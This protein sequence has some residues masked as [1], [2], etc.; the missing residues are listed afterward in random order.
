MTN[1]KAS[2]LKYTTFR[3]LLHQV[4]NYNLRSKTVKTIINVNA[5]TVACSRHRLENKPNNIKVFIFYYVLA[6]KVAQAHKLRVREKLKPDDGVNS[7]TS[8]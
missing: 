2:R 5:L 6:C 7:E 8:Y 3:S 4:K 1:N